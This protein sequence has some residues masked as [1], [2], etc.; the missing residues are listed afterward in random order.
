[1]DALT[2]LLI[3]TL[4]VILAVCLAGAT[5]FGGVIAV[6]PDL[7]ARLRGVS[8]QRVS[9]RRATRPLDI[10]RNVDRWFYRHHRLYGLVVVVLA[11]FLLYFLAFGHA[12][13]AWTVAFDR[14]YRE[15]AEMGAEAARFVLWIVAILGVIVGTL[16]FARPSALK[17]I[18]RW[19]NRWITT[20]KLT[21]GLDREYGQPDAWAARHPRALG[22][23]IMLSAGLVLLALLL[24][25]GAVM[26]SLA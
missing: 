3:P 22:I 20:R 24:H 15:L 11:V 10:P 13:P 14:E 1:M 25:W 18:E 19:A 26:R 16:V 8:D 12:S 4:L 23:A 2:A 21:R 9:L 6:R 7:L 5:V 17:G